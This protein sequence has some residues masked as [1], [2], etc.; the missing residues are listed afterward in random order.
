MPNKWFLLLLLILF[1]GLDMSA[2]HAEPLAWDVP[3]TQLQEEIT[4]R[5]AAVVLSIMIAVSGIS[6]MFGTVS[7][8]TQVCMRYVLGIGL[9]LQFTQWMMGVFPELSGTGAGLS[10]LPAFTGQMTD[11]DFLSSFMSY[12]IAL[13]L[14]G[15]AGIEGSALKLLGILASIEVVLMVI[16][17]PEQDH[18][19]NL[20]KQTLKIG[21]FIF[22][23]TEWIG[24]TYSIAAT[25]SASFEKLGLI[26]A[27][28]PMLL[29]NSIVN[30]GLVM[31]DAIWQETM[32]LGWSSIGLILAN[33]IILIGIVLTTFFTAI[34][35]FMARVEFWTISLM[36]IPL[37]PFGAYQHTRFLF[38]KAIG[39]VFNLG[40]KVGVTSFIAA[41]AGPIMQALA[42]PMLES[43]S[44][45]ES[46]SILLRLLL[47]CLVICVMIMKI[48]E[49]V[50]GLL[51]G[52]P[53]LGGG[54]LL[55]PVTTAA[56]VAA[57]AYTGGM[58]AAGRVA[59]ASSMAGG[60]NADGSVHMAGVARNL[61]RMAK[62]GFTDPFHSAYHAQ[63]HRMEYQQMNDEQMNDAKNGNPV[64]FNKD[65][66]SLRKRVNRETD[67]REHE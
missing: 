62:A 3:L 38:E 39:A 49:L 67:E 47:G 40:I 26:A 63:R 32:K 52:N 8:I 25:I 33:L 66:D 24:G 23:I 16:L 4:E 64:Q 54:D 27:G 37:L 19:K 43:G 13:C 42:D 51:S 17:Q 35:I 44:G 55:S 7:G 34:Q 6:L 21:F 10:P 60:R 12:Y 58:A 56:G 28:Q 36:T 59:L 9:A 18:V 11:D 31:I 65:G 22:L 61:G 1:A 57:A 41:I 30:N 20:L 2:C 48:P 50:Q 29:P 53:T 14:H 5:L 15:A 46:L 45:A